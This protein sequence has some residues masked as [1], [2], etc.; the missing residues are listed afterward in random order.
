MSARQYQVSNNSLNLEDCNSV[1]TYYGNVKCVLVGVGM[2][3]AESEL[4]QFFRGHD[5]KAYPGWIGKYDSEKFDHEGSKMKIR[6]ECFRIRQHLVPFKVVDVCFALG[7]RVSGEELCLQDDGGGLVNKVFGG[8][9]IKMNILLEK[10]GKKVLD[11]LDALDGYNWGGA[12]Y[13]LIVSSLTRS[14]EVY[15]N[16]TNS[17]EIYLAGCVPFLQLWVVH[18]VCLSIPIETHTISFPRF[19]QWPCVKIRS[20]SLNESFFV[21]E[22][23][24]DWAVTEV[25]EG[26]NIVKEAVKIGKEHHEYT[27]YSPIE[28]EKVC[29][30]HNMC[31][32]V[33]LQNNKRIRDVEDQL[34][35]VKELLHKQNHSSCSTPVPKDNMRSRPRRS[36]PSDSGGRSPHPINM[37][38]I[39]VVNIKSNILTGLD[40]QF[41]SPEAR[42]HNMVMFFATGLF[43]VDQ[44]QKNGRVQHFS[45]NP[46]FAGIAFLDPLG[47]RRGQRNKIDKAMAVQVDHVYKILDKFGGVNSPP[48]Q[49]MIVE[50]L[51]LKYIEVWNG[52]VD[53]EGTTMP[54]YNND[55]LQAFCQEM[56]C[57]WVL[58][59]RNAE[60]ENVLRE[61]NFRG[62]SQ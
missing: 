10:L 57:N 28:W 52:M 1:Q 13:D 41:L 53:Y 61:F 42:V 58:D 31:E 18:H 50:F 23:V 43:M 32:F 51:V 21:A 20:S 6:V 30:E 62:T 7:L 45:F 14:S 59:A 19:L 22:I 27:G 46:F 29:N 8:E 49:I 60:R 4:D 44:L 39:V 48:L 11:N 40:L 15:N 54:E 24:W 34:R 25:E 33:L 12:M 16:Q 56:V 47:H 35:V 2:M 17:R 37:F 26:L 9:D 3:W 38:K 5:C 36:P 55:E